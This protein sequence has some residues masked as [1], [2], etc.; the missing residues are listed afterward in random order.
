MIAQTVDEEGIEELEAL[1]DETYS[2]QA[3]KWG[4][5]TIFVEKEKPPVINPNAVAEEANRKFEEIHKEE[6]IQRTQVAAVKKMT[7]D[8]QAALAQLAELAQNDPMQAKFLQNQ[9]REVEEQNIDQSK[10]LPELRSMDEIRNKVLQDGQKSAVQ[11]L[12]IARNNSN[13]NHGTV[14]LTNYNPSVEFAKKFDLLAGAMIQFVIVVMNQAL[15]HEEKTRLLN[16]ALKSVVLALQDL[17]KI[18]HPYCATKFNPEDKK[19]LIKTGAEL[20][21]SVQNLVQSVKGRANALPQF[22]DRAVQ[23]LNYYTQVFVDAVW[24]MHVASELIAND[25]LDAEGREFS[26][27]YYYYYLEYIY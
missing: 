15:E 7:L 17:F 23:N 24:N 12:E 18:F 19:K 25:L 10:I 22:I 5:K 6:A 11:L 9:L 14:P 8:Q 4:D 3:V 1:E 27:Y 21:L 13:A 26:V 16:I 20:Q 2:D